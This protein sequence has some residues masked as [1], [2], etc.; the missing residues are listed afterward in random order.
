MKVIL[1]V[2]VRPR[3]AVDSQHMRHL[4]G[5]RELVVLQRQRPRLAVHVQ[6]DGDL[7]LLLLLLKRR[8]RTPGRRYRSPPRLRPPPRCRGE[9]RR[10]VP[11][12]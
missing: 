10:E 12:T 8:R 6:E 11:D 3:D 7:L 1:R 5:E 4:P 2:V 9:V